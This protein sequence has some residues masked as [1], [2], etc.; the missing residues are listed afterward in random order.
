MGEEAV[1]N[2][3]GSVGVQHG[4]TLRRAVV[5]HHE[6]EGRTGE[7]RAPAVVQAVHEVAE[8]H[9]TGA[10]GQGVG[11]GCTDVRRGRRD[12]AH[13]LRRHGDAFDAGP[14]I[15]RRQGRGQ[16]RGEGQYAIHLLTDF[17]GHAVEKVIRN[18]HFRTV[19]LLPQG[20]L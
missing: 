20:P 10:E 16:P 5:G 3:Q 17:L 1:K 15:R 12:P 8:G 18:R 7:A 4:R 6:G 19:S 11:K 2:L 13:R 14:G 9:R